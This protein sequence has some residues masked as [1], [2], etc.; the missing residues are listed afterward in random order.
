MRYDIGYSIQF[1]VLDR[2]LD[3]SSASAAG[4]ADRGKAVDDG[5]AKANGK[6]NAN[7]SVSTVNYFAT[8][9]TPV[10]NLWRRCGLLS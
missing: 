6:G 7:A 1:V 5:R 10:P 3:K 4:V 9:L 2:I 8:I